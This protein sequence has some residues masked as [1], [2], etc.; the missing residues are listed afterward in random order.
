M[1]LNFWTGIAKESRKVKIM[2]NIYE[3]LVNQTLRKETR[4]FFMI[5]NPSQTSYHIIRSYPIN[6]AV[7][8]RGGQVE[9]KFPAGARYRRNIT[10][11]QKYEEDRLQETKAN[12]DG[13]TSPGVS[14]ASHAEEK[15]PSG[16]CYSLRPRRDQQ[17]ERLKDFELD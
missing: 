17:L 3:V 4:F 14:E 8:K 15:K 9:I 1:T 10:H 7:N 12:G 2:L 11:L 16:H 5:S 13:E 6:E